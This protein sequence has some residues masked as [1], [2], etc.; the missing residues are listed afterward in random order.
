V[1]RDWAWFLLPVRWG[2]PL[3]PSFGWELRSMDVGNRAPYGPSYHVAWNRNAPGH[4]YADYH[5]RRV[6]WARGLIEDLL[7]PWYYPYL[8]RRPRYVHD[9]GAGISRRDLAQLGLAPR[10]GHGERGI[11]SPILGANILFPAGE[12]SDAYGRSTGISLYRN[13]WVKARWGYLEIAG[14]Y[15]RFPRTDG[16][17]GSLFVYPFTAGF[18]LRAPDALFRPYASAGAGIF[19]WES[20]VRQQNRDQLIRSGWNPGW[21][22]SLG[23]EYYLRPYVALDVA[24]RYHAAVPVSLSGDDPARP[25][26][27]SGISI[28]HYLRF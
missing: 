11:G 17:G 9:P 22:G 15:Q 24:F 25:I 12:L 14:G 5:V 20:R 23:V 10:A 21:T 4:V 2:F 27:F 19:G 13:L 28:G 1:L 3:V 8:F 7:Q 18:S 26:R 6:G 16:F